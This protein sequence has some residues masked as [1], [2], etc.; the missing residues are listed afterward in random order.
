MNHTNLNQVFDV[1][2]QVLSIK[3]NGDMERD[4]QVR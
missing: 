4:Q 2:G 1:V 3:K